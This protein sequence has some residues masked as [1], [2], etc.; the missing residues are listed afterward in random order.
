MGGR[1]DCHF[2]ERFKKE[3]VEAIMYHQGKVGWQ[4]NSSLTRKKALQK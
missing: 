3:Y 1:A 2:M 4:G